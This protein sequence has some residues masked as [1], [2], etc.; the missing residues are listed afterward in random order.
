VATIGKRGGKGPYI[1][2]W[3]DHEGHRRERS[4]RTTDLRTAERLAAKW[5]GDSMLR[6]EKVIDPRCDRYGAHETH[7]LADHLKAWEAALTGKGNTRRHVALVNSRA[8][9]VIE[10]AGA[11]R[12]SD[13]VPSRILAAI[14]A[15]RDGD[16]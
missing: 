16:N 2:R 13:L 7:A 9:R 3:F 1:V 8:E 15:V 10:L 11:T 14:K 12:I 4:A 5:E 6:R